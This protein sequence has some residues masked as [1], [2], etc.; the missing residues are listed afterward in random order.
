MVSIKI[1]LPWPGFEPGLLRNYEPPQRRVLTTRRSR[2]LCMT[3]D[4]IINKWQNKSFKCSSE[5]VSCICL[6]SW[7]KNEVQVFHL[8]IE[9]NNMLFPV[10]LKRYRYMT[11]VNFMGLSKG[12][13]ETVHSLLNTPWWTIVSIGMNH[14]ILSQ[15]KTCGLPQ[16]VT[17]IPYVLLKSE[18]PL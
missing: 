18:H 11:I 5:H 15:P 7:K 4:Y 10:P 17:H 8:E 3:K 16:S 12:T 6:A 13:R 2:H 1:V 9:L 14:I